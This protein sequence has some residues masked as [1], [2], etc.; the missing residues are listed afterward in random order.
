MK[1][2]FFLVLLSFGSVCFSQSVTEKYNSLYQRYEYFDS[3]GN[4]IGYKK[5]NKLSSQWE[6]FD[7]KETE[8]EK[9]PRQYGEYIQ[10]YNL[11]LIERALQQKQQKYQS[12]F[13]T[14]KSTIEYIMNDIQKMEIESQE[15]YKILSEFKSAISRNLNNIDIDY[16][17]NEQTEQVIKW[18]YQTATLIIKNSSN[19]NKSVESNSNYNNEPVKNYYNDLGKYFEK[20]QYVDRIAYYNKNGKIIEDK[21]KLTYQSY[22]FL[23]ENKIDF[24]TAKGEVLS[25]ELKNVTYNKELSGY[26]FTS[27]WG[28]V[29][30]HEDLYYVKFYDVKDT[31]GNFYV[32]YISK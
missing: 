15:K 5:Y 16:G 3:S 19:E 22:V 26:E 30:I 12:N 24:K 13:K 9:Q 14:V 6:Y 1:K 7:L 31:S 29:F 20:K 11:D 21:K 23:N 8:Y 2:I 10:P 18:L 4:I 25:R 17:S 27:N 28:T 32:Y